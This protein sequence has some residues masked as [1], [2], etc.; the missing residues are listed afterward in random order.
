MRCG[1][2][3]KVCRPRAIS[4]AGAA[5]AAPAAPRWRPAHSA[6]CARRAAIRCR[7]DGDLGHVASAPRAFCHRRRVAVGTAR[8]R[9]AEPESASAWCCAAIRDGAAVASSTPMTPSRPRHQ[10]LLDRRVVLHRPV[11]VEM[12]RRDVEQHADRRHRCS[13]SGRSGTTTL[14]HYAA[15]RRAAPA[16]ASP[17]RCCRPSARRA[18]LRAGCAR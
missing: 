11:A 16:T 9:C 10:A 6:H 3:G 5:M 12:I 1:S 4:A 17:C 18:R 2:P 13:A 7:R 15:R 14:D 8:P